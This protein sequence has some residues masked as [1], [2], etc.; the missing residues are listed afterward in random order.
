MLLVVSLE[1]ALQVA[2]YMFKAMEHVLAKKLLFCPHADKSFR[3]C[4]C[5][6]RYGEQP[7]CGRDAQHN[8]A[9]RAPTLGPTPKLPIKSFYTL[10]MSIGRRYRHMDWPT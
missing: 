1:A 5:R 9:G 2:L 7:T 6:H 10:S 4:W 3:M 8:T